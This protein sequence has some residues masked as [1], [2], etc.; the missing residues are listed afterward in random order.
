VTAIQ[1]I[2][3]GIPTATPPVV[4]AWNPGDI[5]ANLALSNGDRTVTKTAANAFSGVRVNTSKSSGKW[6]FEVRIDAATTS[7]FITVGVSNA[8]ETLSN[9]TGSSA[10]GWSYYQQTGEKANN[11]VTVAFG[12]SYTTA[13]VVGVAVDL[14]AGKVWFAK[15][16]TWQGSGNPAAGTG[17]AF[18]GLSGPQFPAVALHRGDA[19]AHVVTG[20]FKAA[21][22]TQT[23][24]SGFAAWDT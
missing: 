19:P 22:F 6:Y 21:D 7:P 8:S 20:R 16:G 23:M 13:D 17:E 4:V 11:G 1:Q 5:G 2:L 9:F 12:A 14:D 18:S 15:N 24:P 3:L 10:N